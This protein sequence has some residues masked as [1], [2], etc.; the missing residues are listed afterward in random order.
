ME[1]KTEPTPAAETT[2]TP[3]TGG[4]GVLEAFRE[5]RRRR[6]A[7]DTFFGSSQ[8]LLAGAESGLDDVRLERRRV[9]IME[10]AEEAGMPSELAQL[11]YGVAIE[12]GIDPALGLELV[13][14]GLGVAPPEDG[15]ANAPAAPATD[16]YL[17][18]WMFGA[19]PTDRM[20]RER[21]LRVSFRRL[22]GL[23]EEHDELDAAFHAFA[24][25]PDVGFFGY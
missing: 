1:P 20:L 13:R 11:M 6:R 17:P 14:S 24:E 7:D 9:D 4:H 8:V 16:K 3:R 18:G 21:M 10:D 12:E 25:E 5:R 2:S 19:A 23:L 22:R 15:V